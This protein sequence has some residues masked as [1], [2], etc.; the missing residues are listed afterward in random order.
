M[1]L[2]SDLSLDASKF[3]PT[4]IS[5]QTHDF[6][7]QLIKI[8]EGGP[9]WWEVSAFAQHIRAMANNI[10]RSAQRNTAKCAGMAKHHSQNLKF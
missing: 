1:P 4:A 6:N 9:K 7:D 3:K 5:K 10:V 2:K 8:M